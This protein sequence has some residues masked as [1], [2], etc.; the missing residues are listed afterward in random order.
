MEL[1]VR[2]RA[3]RRALTF[4]GVKESPAGSN[5]G[6]LIDKWLRSAGIAVSETNPRA[7]GAPWCMA[8]VH[9][10]YKAEGVDLGGGASV[11]FFQDWARK[12]GELVTRPLRGDIVCY[13][14]DSNGWPDHVGIVV[15]VLALRWRGKAFAGYV[16]TVE[17]NT[18]VS[19]DSNGGQVM[20]RYRWVGTC[21]FARVKVKGEK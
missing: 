4:V 8:F 14:W 2:E 21:K 3:L 19:N 20:I 1:S 17:G 10:M 5:R 9:A 16:K 18:S 12:H 13:D 15:R 6:P 11:G 7:Q